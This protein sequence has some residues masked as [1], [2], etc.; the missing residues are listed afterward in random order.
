[1][2]VP[3]PALAA[4]RFGLGEADLAV[5]GN[6]AMAWL[7]A[8]I[9]P[10]DAQQPVAEGRGPADARAGPPPRRRRPAAARGPPPEGAEQ[11]LHASIRADQRARLATAASTANPFA[12]RLAMFWTNHFTVSLG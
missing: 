9:G 7:H 8:Q 3:S 5:V 2:F 6:D 10:A 12:E 1:M 4:H 11:A